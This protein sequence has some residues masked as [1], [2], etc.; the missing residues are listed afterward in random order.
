MPRRVEEWR[1]L[2]AP[3]IPHDL[4][5]YWVLDQI[6]DVVER[7][8]HKIVNLSLGPEIAVEGVLDLSV[9]EG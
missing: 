5:G 4:N 1:F 7:G 3:H 2:P 6:R 8:D 9:L